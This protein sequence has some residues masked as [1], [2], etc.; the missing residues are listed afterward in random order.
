MRNVIVIDW[1]ALDGVV[2]APAAADEDTTGAFKHRGW[3]LRYFGDIS[4]FWMV[5]NLTE[6]GGFLLGRRTHEGFAT[7]WHLRGGA[8]HPRAPEHKAEAL[9]LDDHRAACVAQLDGASG[10]PEGGRRRAEAG[11]QRRPLRDRQHKVGA[12]ADRARPGRRVPADDRPAR[13]VFTR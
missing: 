9:G 1:M 5:K 2:Q 6:A 8:G 11:G 7:H 12:G 4:M 10:R 13:H 3:H